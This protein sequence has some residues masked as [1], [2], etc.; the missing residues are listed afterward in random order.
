[1][2]N[3]PLPKRSPAARLGTPSLTE[4]TF[5]TSSG[6]EVPAANKIVPMNMPLSRVR[7]AMTL[8]YCVILKATKTI[9]AA[10]TANW[11]QA[12]TLS[13][14]LRWTMAGIYQVPT[15]VPLER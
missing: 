13:P 4:L 5:V 3:M 14:A 1:M 15:S 8:A 10:L 11:S 9:I 2:L 7:R 6:I 12:I